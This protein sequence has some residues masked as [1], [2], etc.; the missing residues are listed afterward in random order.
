MRLCPVI[1]GSGVAV[2]MAQTEC[3]DLLLHFFQC[4]LVVIP[5]P[6]KILYFFVLC[7]RNMDRAEIVGCQTPGNERGIPLIRFDFFLSDRPHHGGGCQNNAAHTVLSQLVI[8]FKPEAARLI[9]AY[10]VNIF[11]VLSV[12]TTDT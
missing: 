12:Q 3:Q 4:Q 9:T 1:L 6:E 7:S 2:T 11:L 10:K 8:Q 5:H